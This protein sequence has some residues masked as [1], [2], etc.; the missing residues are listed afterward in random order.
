MFYKDVSRQIQT[1]FAEFTPVVEPLSLDEAYLDVTDYLQ[2]GQL[3][4]DVAK[5]IRARILAETG[6]TASAGVSYNKFLAKMA[7]SQRKPNGQF[8]IPPEKGLDFIESLPIQ[9]FLWR[10]DRRRC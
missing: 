10:G 7:S 8:V 6:L 3:A 1:I 9:K 5:Q 4:S 2:D